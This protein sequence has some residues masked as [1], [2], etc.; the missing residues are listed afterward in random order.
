MLFVMPRIQGK[1]ISINLDGLRAIIERD[2][3]AMAW[4]NS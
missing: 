4:S 2:E 3:V 1:S